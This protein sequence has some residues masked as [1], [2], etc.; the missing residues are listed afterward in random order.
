MTSVEIGCVNLSLHV[1]LLL[2]TTWSVGVVFSA[3]VDLEPHYQL[4]QNKAESSCSQP[5]PT[6]PVFLGIASQT[7]WKCKRKHE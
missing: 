1:S 6:G 3:L 2:G 7:M 5:C 4:G